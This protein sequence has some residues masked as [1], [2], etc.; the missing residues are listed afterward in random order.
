MPSEHARTRP[1]SVSAVLPAYNEEA[2]IAE[3]LRRTHA[4]L[5]GL[6]APAFEVIVVDDGSTDSTRSR[7]VD[8]AAALP[9]V[10]VVSH[11]VNRGYG[12]AL[13]TGFEAARCDAIFLMD[14][15][16]QFDPADIRL[17]LALWSPTAVVCGCRAKRRDPLIRRVNHRVF[18]RLVAALFGP[19]AQDVNCAFKLF[20][21]A[22]GQRLS[23]DGALISTELLSRARARGLRII[24]TP[25]PHYPRL[26]GKPTGARPLVILRAFGELWTL[27]RQLRRTRPSARPTP[28]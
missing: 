14:S 10:R 22:L 2:V 15:D 17:L 6:G 27:R 3:T 24:D 26:T 8:I 9:G 4:A 18:F 21:R 5:A 19:T 28:P 12:A 11:P 16:G 20:P 25:V 7:C 1:P 13:R 23:A